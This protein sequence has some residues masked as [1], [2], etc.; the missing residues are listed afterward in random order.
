MLE[1]SLETE[2]KKYVESHGCVYLKFAIIGVAGF[3]DRIVIGKGRL[4][5][6]IEW[7]RPGAKNK[8]RKGEALQSFRH[9]TLR[10]FGFNVYV[11]DNLEEAKGVLHAEFR[12]VQERD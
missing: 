2:F 8:K 1:S 12:G 7:K 11:L 6:F 9:K 4:I 3:P 5:F 10:K